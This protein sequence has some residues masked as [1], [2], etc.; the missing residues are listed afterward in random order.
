MKKII[1][2]SNNI[3]KIKEIS[4]LLSTFGV[5]VKSLK[6]LNL[7]DPIEDGK[8]FEENS[9]IKARYAFEKTGLPSLAD[10]S[11][12]CIEML[13]N[14][15]GLSSARFANASGGYKNAFKIINECVSEKHKNAN[16]TTC[17]SFIYNKDGQIIEKIFEG[18][19][20][21]KFTYPP[22]GN[23]GFAYCPCFTPNNY[24]E[25]FGEMSEEFRTKINHRA[26]ALNKFLEFF[27]SLDK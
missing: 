8:T 14:F 22:R 13:N 18:K 7:G 12:F 19:I 25:T 6:D 2:A 11:G 15:P 27:K 24:E 3:N 26:I 5:E 17:L 23:N 1:L 16:F 20:D 4:G 21:G 9:L 10:D